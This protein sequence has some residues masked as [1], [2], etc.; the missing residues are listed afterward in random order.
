MNATL[1][2]LVDLRGKVQKVLD[3]FKELANAYKRPDALTDDQ[4]GELRQAANAVR[5]TLLL[6]PPNRIDLLA[7]R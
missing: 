1:E 5:Q 6:G 2:K 4:R 3:E 7:N